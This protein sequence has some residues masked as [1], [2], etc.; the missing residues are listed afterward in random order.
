MVLQKGL[1]KYKTGQL[2]VKS[3]STVLQ[4]I[5]GPSTDL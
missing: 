1:A 2:S 3:L 5:V 4:C